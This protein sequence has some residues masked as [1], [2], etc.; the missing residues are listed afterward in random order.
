MENKV[1]S[2]EYVEKNYIHKSKLYAEIERLE[3]DIYK[4][5]NIK[6]DR[7]SQYDKVRLKAYITKSN[8]IV[9]RLKKIVEDKKDDIRNTNEIAKP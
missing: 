2:R 7:L 5:R 9:I 4:T 8:E 1:V 3:R 6:T